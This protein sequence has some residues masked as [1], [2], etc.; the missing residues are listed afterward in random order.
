[1]RITKVSV[2]KLFGLFD[3]EI[4]LNKESR[5]TIIHGPNGV[6][7]TVM[8]RMINAFFNRQHDVIADIPFD[9]LIVT[10]D[11]PEASK[12]GDHDVKSATVSITKEAKQFYKSTV[13]GREIRRSARPHRVAQ[14]IILTYTVG[15]E[16]K[17]APYP[18]GTVPS[19]YSREFMKYVSSTRYLDKLFPS[20]RG[21]DMVPSIEELLGE[22]IMQESGQIAG[23]DRREEPSWYARLMTE[24]STRFIQTQ[25]LQEPQTSPD[26]SANP[27]T[28]RSKP[29]RTTNLTVE[30]FSR[31]IVAEIQKVST[32][33][34]DESQKIDREFPKNLHE[35]WRRLKEEGAIAKYTQDELENKLVS[36]EEKRKDLMDLG[37]LEPHEALT[38]VDVDKDL[39][40][41]FSIYVDDMDDKFS[42]Y[43]AMLKRLQ[44]LTKSINQR[45]RYKRLTIDR[46]KGFIVLALD[47]KGEPIAERPIPIGSL[48][49][50]EQHELVLFYQLLFEESENTLI[51]IDEPEISLHVEWQDSFLDDINEI[52]EARGFY[53]LIAT[54]SP[55]IIGDKDEWLVG[56]PNTE[57]N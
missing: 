47:E 9:Q 49:S 22:Y 20:G 57:R 7:K 10:L 13:R 25:R 29:S 24:V 53:V 14:E 6:G 45:F 37:L 34:G 5:I 2:K 31:D 40:G 8:F 18:P 23:R 42:V 28:T 11:I 52:A 39:A 16:T 12:C 54:H 15:S 4:P 41:V 48:S 55:D 46:D 32:R 38:L 1:M 35:E 56:I 30:K 33:Y 51:L 3:H 50:G 43:D 36:L 17:S 44:I 26:R 21:T 27:R 19:E